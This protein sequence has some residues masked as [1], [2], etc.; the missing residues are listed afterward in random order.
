MM[1]SPR[2]SRKIRSRQISQSDLDGVVNLLTRGFRIRTSDYW[3]Q[4]VA[5]LGA[6]PTPAGFPKY[7][8]L[9]EDDGKPVGVILLIFSSIPVGGTSTTRCNVSSWYVDPAY[10]VHASML[11]SQAIKHKNVTYV[12]ISPAIHTRPIVEAQGFARFSSGQFVTIPALTRA[13]HRVAAKVIASGVLPDAPFDPSERDL[14]A[15]HRSH[16]CL[17]LWVATAERACPFVFMRR[18]VKGI[19]PC[20]QLVYCSDIADFVRLA[21]PLGQYLAMQGHPVVIIDSNGRIPGLAGVYFDNK[22]PKYFKGPHQ[23]PS[24]DLAFTEAVMFGL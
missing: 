19:I 21:R 3:Q 16:G 15:I 2:T 13:T 20:A 12:N 18:T 17:C 23:P 7:G 1:T 22:S 4:A 11:I 10:R 6:H 9:L 14:L 5:T 8:Y 24:G